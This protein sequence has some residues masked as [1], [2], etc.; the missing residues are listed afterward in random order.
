MNSWTLSLH[1]SCLCWACRWPVIDN[2]HRSWLTRCPSHDWSSTARVAHHGCISW[3]GEVLTPLKICKRGQ[4][5]FD[6]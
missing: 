6:P 2:P 1:W 3:G 4:S 5:I